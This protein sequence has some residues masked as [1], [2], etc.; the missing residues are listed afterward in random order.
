M[1]RTRAV[2]AAPV[3]RLLAAALVVAPL[4]TACGAGQQAAT[5]LVGS[6]VDGTNA[7]V[8]PLQVRFAH[9]DT[10][11]TGAQGSLYLS[12]FNNS[13]EADELVSVTSTA[14]QV[15]ATGTPVPLPSLTL[16]NL[17]PSGGGKATFALTPSAPLRPGTTIGVTLRFA[18]AGTVDL[19]VPVQVPSERAPI[20]E[21]YK[22]V[23]DHSEGE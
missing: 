8:G 1:P 7:A 17:L 22:G 18:R 2:P 23:L 21:P 11:S 14:G 4:L 5:S 6:S 19:G 20:S 13:G 12:V 9:V 10:D 16:V 15:T 3:V